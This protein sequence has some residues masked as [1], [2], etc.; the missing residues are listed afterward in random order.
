MNNFVKNQIKIINRLL[1]YDERLNKEDESSIETIFKT[2]HQQYSKQLSF[3]IIN[4]TI[5]AQC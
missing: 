4:D 3:F 1:L 2:L 5:G